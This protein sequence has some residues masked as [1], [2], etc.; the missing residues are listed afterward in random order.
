ML[1][2]NILVNG[3]VQGV[4]FRYFVSDV[5]KELELTGNVKNNYDGTVEINV[6]SKNREELDNFLAQVKKGPPL[7]RVEE[8]QTS[9]RASDPPLDEGF[10]IKR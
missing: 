10:E 1:F 5:A 8:M 4:G 9:V 7:A 6:Y 2:A 3:R